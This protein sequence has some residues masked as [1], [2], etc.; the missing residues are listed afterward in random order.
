MNPVRREWVHPGNSAARALR[1]ATMRPD[2]LARGHP[3][4]GVVLRKKL[5]VAVTLVAALVVG[6]FGAAPATAVETGYAVTVKV[7]NASGTPLAEASVSLWS[8]DYS[9]YESGETAANGVATLADVPPGTFHVSARYWTGSATADVEG[10]VTVTSGPVSTTLVVPGVTLVTGKVTAGGKPLANADLSFETTSGGYGGYARTN[11][12]GTYVATGLKAGSYTVRYYTYASDYLTTYYGS[13]V[14][15]PDAKVL[16]VTSGKTTAGVDIA[17][18]LAATVTGKVVDSAGKAVSGVWVSV[19]N[20]NRAG[21]ASAKTNSQGV[22]VAKG[23]ASGKVVVWASRGSG[24]SAAYGQVGATAKQGATVKAKAVTLKKAGTST[25]KGKVKTTGTKV[26][27]AMVSLLDSKKRIVRQEAPTSKG[28]VKFTALTAGTYYVTVDGSNTLKKVSVK[29][30]KTAS[31]GT[32]SRGKLTTLKGTVKTS[33]K[34][35]ASG[36]QVYVYDA[37]GGFAGHAKTNSKGRYSVKGLYTGTYTVYAYPKDGSKDASTVTTVKVTKGKNATKNVT[38]AKGATVTGYVKHAGKGVKG[39][40]VYLGDRQAV[41]N[42]KG[43]YSLTGVAAGKARVS[44]SD[45]YVGGY[46]SKSKAVGVKKGK[47]LR[48]A[49]IS[50]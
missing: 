23:L 5:S 30:G 33:G 4:Q 1:A 27:E 25:I 39:V 46:V 28:A 32:L 49:T 22:Y 42:A 15:Q 47:S 44:T 48:V 17:V 29:K 31:F 16:T 35:A 37:N 41:T 21:Y 24:A 40:W 9:V 20:V 11:A 13:T 3:N 34:K 6:L 8:D 10:T 19:S 43:Y 18:K 14:R 26:T 38:L 45:P 2:V 36:V 7:T 12:D 50:V